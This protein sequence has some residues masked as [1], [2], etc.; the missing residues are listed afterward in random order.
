MQVS[1][2]RSKLTG[3]FAQRPPR[4]TRTSLRATRGLAPASQIRRGWIAFSPVSHTRD[5]RIEPVIALNE[6]SSSI[7]TADDLLVV[8]ET[9]FTVTTDEER[10]QREDSTA[11][12]FVLVKTPAL[13]N[14]LAAAIA[15]VEPDRIVELG[16][17]KGGSTALLALLARP[18]KLTAVELDREP[19]A[20]L[21]EFITANG[22][23]DVVSAHYGVD[24]ADIATLGSLVGDDHDGEPLDLIVDDASHLYREARTSFELLFPRLR[25]GGVYMIEDWNWAHRREPLWQTGGGWFHD[26]PALTNLI[27]ELIMIAGTSDELI[28]RITVLHDSVE[29]TR[30]PLRVEQPIRL[31]EHYNNR[32]LQLR[33]LL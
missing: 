30:G 10:Y 2:Y 17:F 24:Q 5:E 18:R 29:I 8:A 3:S 9:E 7:W 31:E 13:V 4:D 11:T 25:L 16:I 27:L 26:R 15:D 28:S 20:A 14:R 1:W 32:G 19:V 23:A 12:R 33:P 6:P 21:E 22:L